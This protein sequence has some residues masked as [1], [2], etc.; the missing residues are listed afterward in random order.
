MYSTSHIIAET[1]LENY[2][3]RYRDADKF[4]VYCERCNRYNACWACPPFDFDTGAELSRYKMAWI[5]GTKID[6]EEEVIAH[7]K[8]WELC[9]PL[10]YQIIEEVRF[11]LDEKLLNMEKKYPGSKAFFAGSCHLCA[12][13]KCARIKG[14]PC[15]FPDRI[16]P[17]LESFGFDMSKTATELLNI[18]MK[19]SRNGVLPPYFI[20]VSGLL[21][22]QKIP[23]LLSHLK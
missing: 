8:G 2:V 14:E 20:L 18:E 17:S 11:A 13:G 22:V 1:S 15:V 21:T 4:I 5:I 19:W 7:N 16:R 10:T 23:L 3:R 12:L 9:T 6:I